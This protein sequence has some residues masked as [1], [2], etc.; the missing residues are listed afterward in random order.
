MHRAHLRRED[1]LPRRV[2]DA[3]D[4]QLEGR[5]EALAMCLASRKIEAQVE[6]SSTRTALPAT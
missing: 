4:P 1:V 3:L 5:S 6:G 2:H